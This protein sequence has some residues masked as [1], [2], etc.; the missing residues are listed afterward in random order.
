M[1]CLISTAGHLPFASAKI[2]T[3]FEMTKLFVQKVV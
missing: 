3:F 1:V 2:D